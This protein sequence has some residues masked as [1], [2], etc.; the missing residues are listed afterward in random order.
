MKKGCLVVLAILAIVIV[1]AAGAGYYVFNNYAQQFGLDPADAVSHETLTADNT[2]VK[3][4]VKAEYVRDYIL[5]LLPP[6]LDEQLP[7]AIAFMPFLPQSVE[8]IVTQAL[9]YEFAILGGAD[10]GKQA[11]DITVFLNEKRGGPVIADYL[12]QQNVASALNFIN[13]ND[14][15]FE[16]PERGVVKGVGDI[17]IPEY[18]ESRVRGIY[19]AKEGRSALA[20][21]G[22]NLVEILIDNAD[23]DGAALVGLIVNEIGAQGL[24]GMTPEQI[25]QSNE[26]EVFLKA[27][28]DI[29]LAANITGPD[30]ITIDLRLATSEGTGL[31][32]RMVI[33]G[34]IN[35]QL[36]AQIK[37]L[38][39][40]NNLDFDFKGGVRA[41]WDP[42][43]EG[44]LT[45]SFVLTGFRNRIE[46]QIQMAVAQQQ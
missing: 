15:G 33:L 1:G 28:Q 12:N 5:G 30:E 23:G 6:G 22:N 21:T 3:A 42:K 41:N 16:L 32:E 25:L 2:R 44:I 17:P 36:Y 14:A 38:C 7:S 27:I 37:K 24:G 29:Y 39:A 10:Y 11:M 4:V 18:I 31:L 45:G 26:F 19:P 20:I 35:D 8:D 34:G 46:Q 40:A 13:W 43:G 9:P